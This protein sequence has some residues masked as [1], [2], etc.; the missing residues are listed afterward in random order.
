M[1]PAN[2]VHVAGRTAAAF[3]LPRKLVVVVELKTQQNSNARTKPRQP[4]AATLAGWRRDIRQ[5][6]SRGSH[7]NNNNNNI[8]LT[9]GAPL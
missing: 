9:G 3:R 2:Y 1:E 6:D 5:Y 8:A 4:T 7:R